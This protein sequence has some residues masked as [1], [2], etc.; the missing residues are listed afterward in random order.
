MRF[1]RNWK[2]WLKLVLAFLYIIGMVSHVPLLFFG[3]A[4]TITTLLVYAS[5][6]IIV[7]VLLNYLGKRGLKTSHIANLKIFLISFLLF[8]LLGEMTLKYVA[9]KNLT[10]KE[11]TGWGYY[12]SPYRGIQFRQFIKKSENQGQVSMGIMAQPHSVKWN[13]GP[14]FS[15][16]HSYNSF[17]L[18][19]VEFVPKADNSDY[20]ILALGDSFTEG[21]GTNQDSTWLKFLCN[22]LKYQYG[23][24]EIIGYNGGSAGSD[25]FFEFSKNGKYWTSAKT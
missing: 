11:R 15:F 13:S 17:G 9:K 16:R 6:I 12:V 3:I 7:W 1:I 5:L 21:I 20:L 18:R 10:Y 8:L 23:N 19:D 4:N 25:P 24:R 22:R 2:R 14:E